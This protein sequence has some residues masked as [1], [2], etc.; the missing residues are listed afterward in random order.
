MEPRKLIQVPAQVVDFRPKADRSYKITFETRE[1]S[2]TEVAILADNYQ[3]E[4]QLVFKP[5]GDVSDADIPSG[6]GDA[7]VKSPSQRLRAVLYIFWRQRGEKGD[8]NAF[9]KTQVEKM[10]DLVKDKL[11]E[12]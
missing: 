5:N 1:L 7:G 6:N 8:F 3:G 2:G 10:I 9:Y 4:G 11:T 12:E